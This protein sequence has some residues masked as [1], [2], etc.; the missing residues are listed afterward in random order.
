MENRSLTFCANYQ[1]KIYGANKAALFS[2]LL[3]GLGHM[4]LGDIKEGLLLLGG[5]AAL[6]SSSIL[7]DHHAFD[8]L[9][10]SDEENDLKEFLS[11]PP[12]GRRGR[13]SIIKHVSRV[14]QSERG[15][16]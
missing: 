12:L 7:F 10:D 6:L 15:K 3:P 9:F 16:P 14:P 5:E 2:S 1:I 11:N 8:Y 4:Y 13:T